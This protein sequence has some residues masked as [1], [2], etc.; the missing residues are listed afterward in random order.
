[1]KAAGVVTVCAALAA[2][3][4]LASE[5]TV[6][7]RAQ[8]VDGSTLKLDGQ[9]IRLWGIASPEPSRPEGM[10]ATIGL[11]R[12]VDGRIVSCHLT[13]DRDHRSATWGKCEA[14]GMDVG[15]L[16]VD[17]GYARDCTAQSNARYRIQEQRARANGSDLT[18][19]F[20]LPQGCEPAVA[21][22][23]KSPAG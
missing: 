3:G 8:V 18:S 14:A 11:F 7:A 2:G 22:A 4:A 20:A 16:M 15:A 9:A 23:R 19:T 21:R 6:T 5:Q 13:G 17:G 10:R 12:L 1:M